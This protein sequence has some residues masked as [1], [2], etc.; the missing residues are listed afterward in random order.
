[1]PRVVLEG[2]LATG[3]RGLLIDVTERQ[4]AAEAVKESE[5]KLREAQRIAHLG[6]WDRDLVADRINWSDETYRI[7]GLQP[8]EFPIDLGRLREMIHADDRQTMV[9]AVA[10][11]IRGGARY[12]VEYRVVR[13]DG[14]VRYVH[15]QGEVSRDQS[16]R[17][18][19]D[20]RRREDITERKLAEERERRLQNELAHVSRVTT[21]GEMATGIAH[22]INQ[23]LTSIS[24]FAFAAQELLKNIPHE[25]SGQL[26]RC[27]Q[28]ITEQSTRAAEIVKR[29][30]RL[31]QKVPPSTSSVNFNELI[32]GT[33]ALFH[34]DSKFQDVELIGRLDPF[35]PPVTA[36]AIQIQQV[37]VN[38]VRN[39]LEAVGEMQPSRRRI[40]ITT[41]TLN[42]EA[43][44]VS[45]QDFGP[46]L[47]AEVL[48]RLF[49]TFNTTKPNGLGMGLAISRSIIE[50]HNGRLSVES[51]AGE[52]ACF[53]F[54][55]PVPPGSAPSR[56]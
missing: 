55:L 50:S 8:Q 47:S 28:H 2:D 34:G 35:L 24:G 21:M 52:G 41:T 32:A 26:T 15:S 51:T 25:D 5:Y 10:E 1:M 36:D 30:R 37:L 40:V 17:P 38:L 27:L 49:E 20:V 48:S 7:F 12:D 42:P 11:A 3:L 14:D 18:C 22:E 29:L 19:R 54:S 4:R 9:D 56:V 53:S 6:Y 39:A 43:I 31:V 44:E 33:L 46:G 16:G 23:P 45:V 13:P